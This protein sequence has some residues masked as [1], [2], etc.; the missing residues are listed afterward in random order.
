MRLVKI[1]KE[2]IA[3]AQNILITTHISPDADGIGSEI[4]LREALNKMG[5]KAI[6][7]NETPLLE[8]YCY[9]GVPGAVISPGRV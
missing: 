8:R 1:F 4:A 5:K 7:V 2:K 3:S 6:C 9:L